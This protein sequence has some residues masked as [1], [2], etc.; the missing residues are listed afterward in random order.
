M[1]FRILDLSIT[2]SDSNP[3]NKI[4][5]IATFTAKAKGREKVVAYLDNNL[6]SWPLAESSMKS[7]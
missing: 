7:V 6:F 4:D 1:M 5:D 2:S 3:F